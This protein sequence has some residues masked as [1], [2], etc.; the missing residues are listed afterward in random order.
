MQYIIV[1]ENVQIL[2]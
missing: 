1:V 2:H